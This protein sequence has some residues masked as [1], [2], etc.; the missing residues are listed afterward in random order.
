MLKV[1][2]MNDKNREKED[3]KSTG[4]S[5]IDLS[6]FLLSMHAQTLVNLGEI[7]NPITGESKADLDAAR[8]GIDIIIML[9][10]KTKGNLNDNEKALLDNILYDLRIKYIERTSEKKN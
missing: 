9:K 7:N 10:E 6:S 3:V 1:K 8:Q 2:T 4:L 5:D